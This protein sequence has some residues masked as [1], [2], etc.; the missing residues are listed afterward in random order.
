M[1]NLRQSYTYNIQSSLIQATFFSRSYA[2]KYI[3]NELWPLTTFLY[4]IRQ[5]TT[6]KSSQRDLGHTVLW[7]SINFCLRH[8]FIMGEHALL[9]HC[10]CIY[11]RCDTDGKSVL[12]FFL[13]LDLHG[14][15]NGL[16]FSACN[17]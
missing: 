10:V 11:I 4:P 9:F 13:L 7:S 6:Q 1:L 8:V 5:L 3:K 16:Q 14:K 15:P 12:G 17:Y 2:Q